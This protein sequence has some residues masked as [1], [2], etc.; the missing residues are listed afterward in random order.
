M[1]LKNKI[2]YSSVTEALAAGYEETGDITF[3]A[4]YVSRRTDPLKGRV[5]QGASCRKGQLF[6]LAP[7]RKSTRYCYR[8]YLQKA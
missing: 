5:Y 8:V 2:A 6:Y 1:K 7:C 3:Q 4:G